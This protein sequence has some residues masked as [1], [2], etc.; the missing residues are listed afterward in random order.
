MLCAASGKGI[1]RPLESKRDETAGHQYRA[2]VCFCLQYVSLL[3]IFVALYRQV[4]GHT[5][6]HI[7]TLTYVLYVDTWT[8]L[9][10]GSD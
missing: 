9:G 3:G 7:K 4:I 5:G 8:S 6:W 10:F 1:H 2:K